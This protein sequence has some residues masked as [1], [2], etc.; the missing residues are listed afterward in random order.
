MSHT[1]S[2]P[3]VNSTETKLRAPARDVQLA[4]FLLGLIALVV[5]LFSLHRPALPAENPTIGYVYVFG[6]AVA[7]P[8]AYPFIRRRISLGD[9]FLR[10]G[11]D[12]AA[13]ELLPS[14]VIVPPQL[15][16]FDS[17]LLRPVSERGSFLLN[18]NQASPIGLESLPGVGEVLARRIIAARPFDSIEELL[19]VEGIGSGKLEQIRDLITTTSTPTTSE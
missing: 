7:R 19:R 15:I 3:V 9:V 8:G 14:A 2:P 4:I 13:V 5:I 17:Q 12:K 6:D 11:G 18:I 16:Y 1:T 10:A